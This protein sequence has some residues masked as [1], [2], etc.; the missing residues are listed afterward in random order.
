MLNRVLKS[1]PDV[2]KLDIL[3]INSKQGTVIQGDIPIFEDFNISSWF[4]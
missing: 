2:K 4:K 1:Y 3:K